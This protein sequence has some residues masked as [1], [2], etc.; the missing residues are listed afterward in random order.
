MADWE[1]LQTNL[2]SA[3]LPLRGEINRNRNVYVCTDIGIF[4]HDSYV[5]FSVCVCARNCVCVCVCL[6]AIASK[7]LGKAVVLI[8]FV[9]QI[10]HERGV[11]KYKT[12]GAASQILYRKHGSGA[13]LDVCDVW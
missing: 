10:S 3:S 13:G 8:Y 7:W 9:S 12:R 11:I 1:R 5:S 6:P 4:I 2:A